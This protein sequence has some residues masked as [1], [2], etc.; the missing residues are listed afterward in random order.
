MRGRQ[1]ASHTVVKVVKA[2][3]SGHAIHVG[4]LTVDGNWL[5]RIFVGPFWDSIFD[6]TQGLIRKPVLARFLIVDL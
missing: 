2:Q 6:S 3:K 5:I 4:L 1:A